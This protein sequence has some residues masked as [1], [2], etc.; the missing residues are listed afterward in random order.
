M[1]IY[2]R[3]SLKD[4]IDEFDIFHKSRSFIDWYC[5]TLGIK[6]PF[7]KMDHVFIP[8][9]ESDVSEHAGDITYHDK[10]VKKNLNQLEY[11][12]FNS[13]IGHGL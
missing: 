10:F 3:D 13:L 7:S 11:E 8:E 1:R 9:I 6:M 5:Q 4:D 2:I 12:Q